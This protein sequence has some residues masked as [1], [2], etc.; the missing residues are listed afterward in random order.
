MSDSQIN[1]RRFR[2]RFIVL[3]EGSRDVEV[4]LGKGGIEIL[5]LPGRDASGPDRL[6]W[7]YGALASETPLS[8]HAIEA[9]VTYSYQPGA[10]LFVADRDFARALAMR[11]P[12]LTVSAQNWRRARPWLWAGAAVVVIVA[13]IQVAGLSPA[14]TI[15]GMLPDS[16]KTDERGPQCLRECRRTGRDGQTRRA[17]VA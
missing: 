5:G 15:A 9:L 3:G 7:P 17:I 16:I 11:A 12:Q 1:M 14:R 13:V 2:G 6:V 4:L 10:R 8:K